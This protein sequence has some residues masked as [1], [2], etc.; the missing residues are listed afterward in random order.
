VRLRTVALLATLG[1]AVARSRRRRAPGADPRALAPGPAIPPAAPAPSAATDEPDTPA[2]GHDGDPP[3]AAPEVGDAVAEERGGAS[4]SLPEAVVVAEEQRAPEVDE[5]DEETAAT[6]AWRPLAAAAAAPLVA[7]PLPELPAREDEDEGPPADDDDLPPGWEVVEV[8]GPAPVARRAEPLR[9]ISEIRRFFRTNEVPVWFVSAT[10]FNLLGIDRWVRR[11][12]Y[13]NYYDSFD[14]HHPNVFVP[15]HLAPPSFDSI[16]EIN[17][18]LLSHKEVI[19]RIRAQG[20]G[21]ALFLMFDEHVEQLAREAGL[22]VAFPPAALRT[23]LDSKIE[24]TRLGNEAGVPSVPNVLGRARSYSGLLSLA[25]GAGLGDD[26]VVQTPYGDSGQTTF[27]I[28][29]EA[30]FDEHRAGLVDEHLKVMKRITCREAAIEG[31]I[32]RHGTLVGP[33]MTE[34]TGFP[35]LTPYGGGWCGND[36]FATALTPRH[37][38]RARDYTQRMG[39][40]L[41][42]EGYRGYFE[43]DFLADMESGE[44]YLGELNPRVTGASSMTNVTAVAYGDMPLFLFHLLEFMDVDYEI[45]VEA[46]NEQWSK[47]S[48]IDEWSQ[49]I[50]KDTADKV[51]LITEAPT[52]GIWR[53]DRAAHGGIRFVRRETDWHSVG[54]E[55]EAFYLRIAQPGGYRYPGA[56]IGILVTRGRLQTDDHELTERARAWITG[57]KRQFTTAPLVPDEPPPVREPGPFSFK[58]L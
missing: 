48:A 11:F 4:S 22:E 34:L 36:V 27:F 57:I 46:L 47:A 41:A 42:R 52:S 24:T 39:E 51:E 49:F 17:A 40:R 53:L 13:V 55:D 31:V 28:A 33:L 9:G 23:R 45:D 44:L 19:D 43:L 58:M 7:A 3:L 37:R 5:G 29:S 10:A 50:L 16:E 32:T 25:R 30:D 35:E 15:T 21:K 12:T 54:D 38:E 8:A 14:G 26:L 1:A 56:D 18:Y 6:A 2:I 20:G